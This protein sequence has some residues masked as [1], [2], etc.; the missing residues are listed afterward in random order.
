M[1]IGDYVMETGYDFGNGIGL[2]ID[3]LSDGI[4][5][6]GHGWK[7]DVL[8]LYDY[9]ELGWTDSDC[10]VYAEADLGRLMGIYDQSET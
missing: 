9:G 5:E 7:N 4:Y 1:K 3:I 10:L 2:I 8:L 6:C